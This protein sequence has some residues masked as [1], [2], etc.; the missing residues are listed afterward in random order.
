MKRDYGIGNNITVE[1]LQGAK[2]LCNIFNE[3]MLYTMLKSNK[4]HIS[5]AVSSTDFMSDAS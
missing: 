5:Q 3:T 2:T 4:M 1:C